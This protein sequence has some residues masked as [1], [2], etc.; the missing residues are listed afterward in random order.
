MLENVREADYVIVGSG[1]T[2]A[3][4]AHS[5]NAAGRDVL[6]LERRDHIAGLCFDKVHDDSG[7][8]YQ[9]YG[10]HAFRTRSDE[11]WDWLNG[12][13]SFYPFKLRIKTNIDGDFYTWPPY[14]SVIKQLCKGDIEPGFSGTPTNFEEAS[15]SKMPKVIYEKFVKSYSEKQWGMPAEDLWI[16]LSGRFKVK[17]D[18]EE[19]CLFDYKYQ[20][21]PSEG[22]S[23]LVGKFLKDVPIVMNYDF[24]LSRDL[25]LAKKKLIYSG[26]LDELFDFKFGKLGY[27]GMKHITQYYKGNGKEHRHSHA[28]YNFPAKKPDHIRSI[29]WAHWQSPSTDIPHDDALITYGIPKAPENTEENAYPMPTDMNLKILEKYQDCAKEMS[30]LISCGRLADY[31]YYDMNHAMARGLSIARELLGTEYKG[32]IIDQP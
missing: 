22:F 13:V 27:R 29:D 25:K 21:L 7:L 24:K 2:G 30:T 15:L 14:R 26:A 5:L 32:P 1:L 6:V 12:F 9:V 3:V 4:I 8:R 18:H 20:G 19:D 28:V 16:S 23:G 17:E 31:K 10:P 11:L